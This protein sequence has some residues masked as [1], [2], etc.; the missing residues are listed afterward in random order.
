MLIP[1]HFVCARLRGS[2]YDLREEEEGKHNEEC[3]GN[4]IAA[5]D[6]PDMDKGIWA[7][8]GGIRGSRSGDFEDPIL[9]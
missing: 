4:S 9:W 3:Q 2:S 6:Q 8:K 1:V 5:G 7:D